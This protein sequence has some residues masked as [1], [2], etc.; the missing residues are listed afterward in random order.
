[1]AKL[2]LYPSIILKKDPAKAL[3]ILLCYNIL[4]KANPCNARTVMAPCIAPLYSRSKKGSAGGRQCP[5]SSAPCAGSGCRTGEVHARVVL[6][7]TET[8]HHT[9]IGSWPYL[10]VPVIEG[11][12]VPYDPDKPRPEGCIRATDIRWIMERGVPVM[13]H[14]ERG[15]SGNFRI[16]SAPSV[17]LARAKQITGFKPF[18]RSIFEM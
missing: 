8:G 14:G 16:L 3:F 1:M 11:V 10:N 4:R 13:V 15:I 18:E 12:F 2:S 17:D 9:K 5:G 7:P 6:S